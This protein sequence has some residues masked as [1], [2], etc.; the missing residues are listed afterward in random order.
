VATPTTGFIGIEVEASLSEITFKLD[1]LGGVGVTEAHFHCGRA[2]ENGPV[3]AFLFGPV[4][5]GDVNG[6]LASGTLTNE[7]FV[8]EADCFMMIGRPVNNV[9]SF[10]FA[11]KDG[12][13]YVNVPTITHTLGEVR[14]QL[15][16]LPDTENGSEVPS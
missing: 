13:I 5:G 12:L 9:A 16:I 11:A 10:F 3:I 6:E 14:G 7:N 4:E 15:I 1:V 8:A 2:G